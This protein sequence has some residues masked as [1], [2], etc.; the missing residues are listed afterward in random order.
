MA[1]RIEALLSAD[2]KAVKDQCANEAL[3]YMATYPKAARADICSLSHIASGVAKAIRELEM[4]ESEPRVQTVPWEPMD[5]GL[6]PVIC[7]QHKRNIA[8]CQ[9]PLP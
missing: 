5:A 3:R 4:K 6:T 8:F 1:E 7:P 2:R 9:C